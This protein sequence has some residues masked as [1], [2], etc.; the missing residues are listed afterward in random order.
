MPIS[1]SEEDLAAAKPTSALVEE[2]DFR[3]EDDDDNYVVAELRRTA[4]G[5]PFRYIGES[6]MNSTYVGAGDL[7]EW[8][9][10]DEVATW[11]DFSS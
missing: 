9:S 5:R 10:E 7:G 1:M 3:A 6:G 4:G 8:L 2:F 11:A